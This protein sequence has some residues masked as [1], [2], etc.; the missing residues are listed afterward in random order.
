M[1]LKQ[2]MRELDAWALKQGFWE[3]VSKNPSL[4]TLTKQEKHV[5]AQKL[6]LVVSEVSEAFE[7]LRT[8]TA[9]HLSEGGK[10]EGFGVECVDAI[11]VL[12]NI[13]TRLEIDVESL[14][15]WKMEYNATRPKYNGKDLG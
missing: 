14:I 11:L 6:M 8:D 13:C 2:L 7:C 5:V 9:F 3:D 12:L 1:E 15:K 4:S 10:P